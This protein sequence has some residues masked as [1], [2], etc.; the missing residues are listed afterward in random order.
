MQIL[1]LTHMHLVSSLTFY[2][3]GPQALRGSLCCEKYQLCFGLLQFLFLRCLLIVLVALT[4]GEEYRGGGALS[5]LLLHVL[6]DLG[7][8][9]HVFAAV[10][11]CALTINVPVLLLV[12]IRRSGSKESKLPLS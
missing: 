5:V 11:Q 9:G 6:E 7:D 2:P 1:Y 4:L 12:Y 3:K 10:L 8:D